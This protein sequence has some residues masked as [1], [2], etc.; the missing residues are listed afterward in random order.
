MGY[1]GGISGNVLP[2]WF[3]WATDNFTWQIN[4]GNGIGRYLLDNTNGGL[5][6]NYVVQPGC[7][8]PTPGC[9]LAATSVNV[10]T[11]PAV[12][13][14][15]GY[16]H[17]WTP[18]LRSTIAYGRSRYQVPSILVGPIESTVANKQLQSASVNLIWGP[19]AFVDIGAEYY[20]GQREVVAGLFGTEQVLIGQFRLK[21]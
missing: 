17:W 8:T 5:A 7:P 1:G 16:L 11:I 12:G 2:G 10:Q 18:N 6:T 15:V 4:A 19:V 13:G 3:G 21:F 14:V 20:W 9:A